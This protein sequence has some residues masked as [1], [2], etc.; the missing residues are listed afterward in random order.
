ML[1]AIRDRE[2]AYIYERAMKVL[3]F[4]T[5]MQSAAIAICDADQILY[6]KSHPIGAKHGDT[7]LPYLEEALRSCAM[8]LQAIDLIAVGVGPGSFTGTR[9]GVSTAK[10]L[11][12]GLA[13]PVVGIISLEVL[14]A[15]IED[16][17]VAVAPLIDAYKGEVFA[18]L[19]QKRR[20]AM[21]Q[22]L[23]APF[24]ASP[25][26]ALKRIQD[27]S[28]A[29]P[30]KV[31]GSGLRRYEVHFATQKNWQLLEARFDALPPILLAE[32]AILK[33]HKLGGD[34]VEALQ[35]CYV[36]ASDAQLPTKPAF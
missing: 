35:P 9:V 8:D 4:D 25:E 2:A 14:A 20:E 30:V 3:A 26:Q 1:V 33:Y 6:E 21:P 34:D 32:L 22:T 31:L 15:A 24:H 17:D 16:N 11:A 27:F 18:G 12:Y 36:R 19:Y 13:K 7:L 23:L 10:A 5:S 28:K 29:G